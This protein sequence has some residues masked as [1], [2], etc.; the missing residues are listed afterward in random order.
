MREDTKL[1][2]LVLISITRQP[3]VTH[4]SRQRQSLF[5]LQHARGGVSLSSAFSQQHIETTMH[6]R[7]FRSIA[8][9]TTAM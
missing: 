1:L 6:R 3:S 4:P 7:H 2:Q 9:E 8:A 5:A